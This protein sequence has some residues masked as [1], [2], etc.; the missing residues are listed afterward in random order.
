M[1]LDLVVNCLRASESTIRLPN[2]HLSRGIVCGGTGECD[3]DV[4]P[5]VDE[6][7]CLLGKIPT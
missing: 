2:C 1:S 7:A 5:S 6:I 4:N 3:L